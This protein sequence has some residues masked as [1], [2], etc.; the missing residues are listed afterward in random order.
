MMK[1]VVYALLFVLC[2]FSLNASDLKYIKKVNQ[3]LEAQLIAKGNEVIQA[4]Y[5]GS[6]L[7]KIKVL[8]LISTPPKK[9]KKGF[10][11]KLTK[12]NITLLGKKSKAN[13]IQ[14]ALRREYLAKVVAVIW[15]IYDVGKKQG[16]TGSSVSYKIIDNG[17]KLYLFLKGY[18]DMA[19][20]HSSSFAYDRNP[21]KKLSSHYKEESPESQFGVD[22]RF[23]AN[24]SSLSI[25]PHKKKHL[26]FGRLYFQGGTSPDLLFVKFEE[27]GIGALSEKVAHGFNFLK[28]LARSK[29]DLSKKRIEKVILPAI[30]KRYLEIV[31]KV[32]KELRT[33]FFLS[34][35]K[36]IKTMLESVRILAQEKPNFQSNEKRFLDFLKQQYPHDDTYIKW[37]SGNEVIM[38]LSN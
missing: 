4:I 23:Y 8:P 1:K 5:S 13:E 26:L 32:P 12:V 9:K 14:K 25:L 6:D 30:A 33:K 36:S 16:V 37:R 3:S 31:E 24:Q 34:K 38:K 22:I 10:L 11:K 2:S 27:Y 28:N 29:A 21:A 35:P 15:K 7:S 20:S 17:K 19:K 18:V